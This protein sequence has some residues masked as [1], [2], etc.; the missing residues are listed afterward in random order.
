MSN[1][2]R[3]LGTCVLGSYGPE[4][5][6]LLLSFHIH[7]QVGFRKGG[8]QFLGRRTQLEVLLAVLLMV[9]LL[10]LLACLLLLGLGSSFGKRTVSNCQ[11][12]SLPDSSS[13]SPTNA[14]LYFDSYSSP[15]SIFLTPSP[16]NYHTLN[17][18]LSVLTLWFPSSP[19]CPP[20]SS[21]SSTVTGWLAWQQTVGVAS[22][23]RRHV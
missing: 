6:L 1:G 20:T 4:E 13:S 9:V 8:I 22:A 14:L 3:V 19:H 21:L 2:P 5:R 18:L 11:L 23:S 10:A 15:P 7:F 17:P 12:H 16:S